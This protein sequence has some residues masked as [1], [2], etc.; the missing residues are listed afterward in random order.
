MILNNRHLKVYELAQ[1]LGISEERKLLILHEELGMKT[2]GARWVPH[3]LN[4]EQN[5]SFHRQSNLAHYVRTL[6]E[7]M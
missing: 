1:A 4:A 6:L 5:T 7:R 3:L 2:L